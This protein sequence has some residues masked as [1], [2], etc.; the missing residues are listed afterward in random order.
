MTESTSAA[1]HLSDSAD[2]AR[3]SGKADQPCA[4]AQQVIESATVRFAGDSGDGMQLAGTQLTATS[5]LAGNDVATFPDF[6][7]EIRAP[8]GTLSGVSG[9][10]VHFA[11]KDIL[12]PGD[13][14]DALVAMNPAA[15]KQNLADLR[16]HGT[17]V[18][19][20]DAFDAKGLKLAGY[21]Q[22]PL[23]GDS[24]NG[25]QLIKVPLTSLTAEAVSET[26]LGKKLS[27]RCRNFFAMGLIY[28]LFGRDMQTTVRFI[29]QKFGDDSQVGAANLLALKAG[30]HFGETLEQTARRYQVPKAPLAPGKYRNLTGNEALSLG[31]ITAAKRSGKQL[32]Y[33]T[34]PITPASDILHE[35]SARKRYGVRTFQAEDE[36]AAICAAIGA[37]FAGEMGVTASAGPGIALKSEALGLAIMMELPLIVLNIQRGGPSTGLP[38]KP[39]QTDLLQCMYGRSGEA[40]LPILAASSPSD[41]FAVVQEA[42]QIATRLMTPVIVMSDAYVANGAEPWRIPDSADLAPIEVTHP[43]AP[44]AGAD[45]FQPYARD[46]L[47]A[48]PWAIPGTPGLMHRLGGLEKQNITGAVSYDPDNHE[49][50]IELR[51]RKIANATHLIPDLELDGAASGDLLVLSWGGTYGATAEAVHNARLRGC[52]A[53]HA[54]LRHLNPFPQNLAELLSSFDKVLVPELNTGQLR[55]LLR[56]R[57]L[58]DIIG[59]N[60]VRGRPFSVDEIETKI[61]ELSG[62]DRL[63][64]TSSKA[65]N[66]AIQ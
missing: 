34:Y 51:A 40:P 25:Y 28:W 45:P 29:E 8:R 4:T 7:A 9:F 15:L 50:M 30:F 63:D 44:Q 64:I 62:S 42:W 6:P 1:A 58:V 41:C 14:L 33:S 2:P 54:H 5:A 46:E 27:E 47:L 66:E 49:R 59:L 21:A 16:P 56:A 13:S 11:G 35:L 18:V 22:S 20:V 65:H 32:L 12:T 23:D 36:I 24:L 61:V 57:Y 3:S 19:D 38:T 60:R 48:R 17:L 10:Q 52:S 26:G 43:S 37:S 39:E 31:L 53:S 55:S